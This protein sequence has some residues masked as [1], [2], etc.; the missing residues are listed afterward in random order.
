MFKLTDDL[1]KE[2]TDYWLTPVP[3]TN[4]ILHAKNFELK[5]TSLS[6][7]LQLITSRDINVNFSLNLRRLRRAV[8]LDAERVTTVSDA[9]KALKIEDMNYHSSELKINIL[10]S[11]DLKHPRD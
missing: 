5:I 8:T 4:H 6:N 1:L 11:F 10:K 7:T 9:I 2:A 3:N